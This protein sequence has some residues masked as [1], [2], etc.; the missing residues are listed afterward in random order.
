[1]PHSPVQMSAF[2]GVFRL[3]HVIPRCGKRSTRRP[4]QPGFVLTRR[5]FWGQRVVHT[6]L[7]RTCCAVPSILA[8]PP[9]PTAFLLRTLDETDLSAQRTP[10]EAQARLP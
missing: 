4:A 2:A 9:L 10:A 3:P 8:L 6:S 7:W 1:M 5:L